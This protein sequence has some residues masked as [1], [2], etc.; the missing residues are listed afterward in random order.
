MGGQVYFNTSARPA[1]LETL[2]QELRTGIEKDCTRLT[3][4]FF[5]ADGMDYLYGS[6]QQEGR[7]IGC[8]ISLDRMLSD[9]WITNL[10]YEGFMIFEQD[11]QLYTNTETRERE[12]VKRLLPQLLTESH[13]E[14]PA[15]A[16][17]THR[18]PG[19]GNVKILI[20]LNQGILE[21]I[22]NVQLLSGFAF[23]LLV[24]VM[25]LLL[26]KL[27]YRVLRPMERFVDHLK[28]SQEDQ[29]WLNEKEENS[30]PEIEY[31]NERF[32]KMFREIQSL[33]IDIYEK[34]LAEKK[35]ILEYAQE[36]IRPHFFLNCMSIV[37]GMAELHQEDE[38]VH[39]LDVLSDYMKYVIQDTFEPR[40]IQDE[41]E[42]IESYMALQKMC[43]PGAFTFEVIQEAPK[44]CKILPLVLQTFVENTVVHGLVPGECVEIAVYITSIKQEL[45]EFL[46]L[47]ISDTGKGF[48]REALQ[49]L[50]ANRRIFYNGCEH[51][52][53]WN[54]RKRVEMFYGKKAEIRFGNM[55]QGGRG[56]L[57]E[58]ILPMIR[59]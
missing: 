37:Q 22:V 48:S 27:Y 30:I 18:I 10:G 47:V 56:T 44:D 6:L 49:M 9:V 36:Q 25:L 7:A 13:R 20:L 2:R 32:K 43:K 45:E 14:T 19:L 51:I 31:A 4:D 53:I 17:S 42:H 34:E 8:I 29:L 21:R 1:Y 35:V 46:Y 28:K 15:Y 12:D 54:T 38:I 57:V 39:M 16:W 52:G 55:G 24:C 50:E 40:L 58:M 33:R 3:W 41:V 59:G 26:W 5:S 23:V 11:G